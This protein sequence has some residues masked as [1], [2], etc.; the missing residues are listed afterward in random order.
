MPGPNKDMTYCNSKAI[1]ACVD[2][3]CTSITY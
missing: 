3:K 1:K 2:A